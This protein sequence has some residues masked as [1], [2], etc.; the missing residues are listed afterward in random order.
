MSLLDKNAF[1]KYITNDL[2]EK[3]AREVNSHLLD[4][5]N[6]SWKLVNDEWI[7]KR[8]VW[9]YDFRACWLEDTTEDNVKSWWC[10]KD[11]DYNEEFKQL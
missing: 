7:G 6:I 11:A 8:S 1:W 3:L 10:G 9:T 2:G 5:D 4:D